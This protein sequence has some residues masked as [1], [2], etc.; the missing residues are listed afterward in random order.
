MDFTNYSLWGKKIFEFNKILNEEFKPIDLGARLQK[1]YICLYSSSRMQFPFFDES[2]VL[3]ST[4]DYIK[5]HSDIDVT[6]A[7]I[8]EVSIKH[9]YIFFNAHEW[10][11]SFNINKFLQNFSFYNILY[12]TS[13]P[14]FS[15]IIKSIKSYN[16]V[17]QKKLFNLQTPILNN[18]TQDDKNETCINNN[19]DKSDELITNKKETIPSLAQN[20]EEFDCYVEVQGFQ[21]IDDSNI[22]Y[23][24]DVNN[25]TNNEISFGE[26]SYE[27]QKIDNR[28]LVESYSF[29]L[30]DCKNINQNESDINNNSYNKIDNINTK[31]KNDGLNL[32]IDEIKCPDNFEENI[33]KTSKI[34]NNL[35]ELN[36]SKVIQNENQINPVND[37]NNIEM[38]NNDCNY[39]EINN[40]NIENQN[41]FN[42]K[43]I[44]QIENT[45]QN[46]IIN[47]PN[48][49]KNLNVY[50]KSNAKSE[51]RTINDKE[52][53]IKHQLKLTSKSFNKNIKFDKSES[54]NSQCLKNKKQS[55]NTSEQ[56]PEFKLEKIS[57]DKNKIILLSKKILNVRENEQSSLNKRKNFNNLILTKTVNKD[58]FENISLPLKEDKKQKTS[59]SNVKIET[60]NKDKNSKNKNKV[61]NQRNNKCKLSE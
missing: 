25:F 50:F 28:Q 36:S 45:N 31:N 57:K 7:K 3:I 32:E 38:L 20:D 17:S 59:D 61:K 19:K 42:I 14:G 11:I 30:K 58:N 51:I 27:K 2:E 41:N 40:N 10:Q 54:I 23:R 34:S 53:Y 4:I 9:I 60:K 37:N 16:V 15:R 12:A 52:F 46:L 18:K 44:S 55:N 26:N 8:S 39:N 33:N 49:T 43:N 47:I 13:I 1:K 5:K 48:D 21:F 22:T 6:V 24:D 29:I 56:I 35:D